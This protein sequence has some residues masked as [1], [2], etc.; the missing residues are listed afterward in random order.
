MQGIEKQSNCIIEV[1]QKIAKNKPKMRDKQ[2]YLL[3]STKEENI[4]DLGV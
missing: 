3:G 1:G 4:C 2:N